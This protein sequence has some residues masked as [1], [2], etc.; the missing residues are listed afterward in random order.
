MREHHLDGKKQQEKMLLASKR[1]RGYQ[2]A[3][4]HI[5]IQAKAVTLNLKYKS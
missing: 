4:I 5:N 2:A 1:Y 3:Y